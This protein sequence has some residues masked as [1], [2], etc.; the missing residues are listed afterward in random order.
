MALFIAW[1]IGLLFLVSGVL[2]F[3]SP[4]A[5]VAFLGFFNPGFKQDSRRAWR[6]NPSGLSF[7]LLGLMMIGA[8][9]WI[10]ISLA[11]KPAPWARRISPESKRL[12]ISRAARRFERALTVGETIQPGHRSGRR[13][14]ARM[15]SGR[16]HS[17]RWS[18][19]QEPSRL[20][21]V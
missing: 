17:L 7:R 16:N 6:K 8:G 12:W 13:P 19:P 21:P 18:A 9:L 15:R 5:F 4:K 10:V 3:F 14:H 20:R 1:A 11:G 2:I